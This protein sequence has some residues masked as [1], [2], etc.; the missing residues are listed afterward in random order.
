MDI[1]GRS[2][3]DRREQYI[4]V[5]EGKVGSDHPA[6]VQLLKQCLCNAPRERPSTEELLTR[7]QGM[8]EEVEGEH[9][10][11]PIRLDMVR[12]RLAKDVKVK[13]RR[14]Q[15]LT[16]QLVATLTMLNSLHNLHPN[17]TGKT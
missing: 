3:V 9:G 7:L 12:L 15:H 14:I 2:E 4:L 17:L 10:G 11:S 6:L 5:L 13:D 16:T 8:R 1:R